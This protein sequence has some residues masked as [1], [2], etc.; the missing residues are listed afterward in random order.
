M[1][2]TINNLAIIQARTNSTRFPGKVLKEICS[3]PMILFQINRLKKSKN[4]NKIVLATSTNKE[5]DHLA[6]IVKESG[7]VVFRGELEDVLGRFYNCSKLYKPRNI[8]RITGDCPLIDPKIVDKVVN[9]YFKSDA[10][11]VSNVFPPTFPD[12][13]D[14]EIFSSKRFISSSSKSLPNMSSSTLDLF[15]EEGKNMDSE[16]ASAFEDRFVLVRTRRETC[17][18]G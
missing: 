7:N 3:M 12:G 18:D 6:Q 1:N 14:V 17:E 15:V 13:L 4:I 2:K 11:Y 16:M 10:E 9:M 8:I 5:D